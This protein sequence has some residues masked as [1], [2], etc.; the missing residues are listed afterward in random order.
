MLGN[1]YWIGFYKKIFYW[2]KIIGNNINYM[3]CGDFVY[4]YFNYGY[5]YF[6]ICVYMYKDVYVFFIL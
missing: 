4:F 1:F 5:V 3:Y 2:I 6:Y